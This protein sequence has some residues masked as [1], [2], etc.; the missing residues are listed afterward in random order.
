MSPMRSPGVVHFLHY[1]NG[2][3]KPHKHK[4]AMKAK[5]YHSWRL[6]IIAA[7]ILRSD[8]FY[9]SLTG[10]EMNGPRDLFEL[11]DRSDE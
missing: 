2:R 3:Q 11:M 7:G 1:V 5:S 10:H 6:A 8:T 9:R 4:Y